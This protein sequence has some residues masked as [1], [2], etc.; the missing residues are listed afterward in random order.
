MSVLNYDSGARGFDP[1]LVGGLG[2]GVLVFPSVIGP[3]FNNGGNSLAN[4]S[5]A[6]KT[7]AAI[8]KSPSAEGLI[9][10]IRAAGN[11]TLGATGTATISLYEGTSLKATSDTLVGTGTSASLAAGSYPFYLTLTAQSSAPSGVMQFGNAQL[12]VDGVSTTFTLSNSGLFGLAGSPPVGTVNLLTTDVPFA[13]ATQFGTSNA[14]NVA[15][16]QMFVL[17]G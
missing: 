4:A 14:A 8:A 1:S 9:L 2:T 12:Y 10:S 16:L 6:V 7:C 11:I 3:G 13:M 5:V 17:E 15:A